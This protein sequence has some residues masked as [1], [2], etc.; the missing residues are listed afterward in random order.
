VACPRR[1][2]LA[3][4]GQ[5]NARR[6]F[7]YFEVCEQPCR[8]DTADLNARHRAVALH[9]VQSVELAG[10]YSSVKVAGG[11]PINNVGHIPCI[12]TTKLRIEHPGSSKAWLN[13]P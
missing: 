13:I 5:T 2:R 10:Y 11:F 9:I 4:A 8:V 3:L 1:D 12:A 6:D 7:R